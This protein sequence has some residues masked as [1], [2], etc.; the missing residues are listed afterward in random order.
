VA[1]ISDTAKLA[2]L[3][4]YHRYW[5]SQMWG[6]DCYPRYWLLLRYLLFH[7]LTY[8]SK[9]PEKELASADPTLQLKQTRE[10]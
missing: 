1:A 10:C 3:L 6:L 5:T 7:S 8:G 2:A 9:R 4:L